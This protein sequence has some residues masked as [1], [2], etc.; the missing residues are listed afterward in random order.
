MQQWQSTPQ[1][2]SFNGTNRRCDRLPYVAR[3][4]DRLH[5]VDVVVPDDGVKRGVQVVEKVHD[6][7]K[8]GR[9]QCAQVLQPGSAAIFSLNTVPCTKSQESNNKKQCSRQ[10]QCEIPCGV[11]NV[12]NSSLFI[13]SSLSSLSSTLH[14]VCRGGPPPVGG[15]HLWQGEGVWWGRGSG[16]GRG[17]GGLAGG[18]GAEDISVQLPYTARPQGASPQRDF[19]Q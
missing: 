15:S 13:N 17:R 9:S 7:E 12:V 3:L 14:A 19:A 10:L 8:V 5:F 11:G 16:R 1:V 6:L 18:R 2:Y 4:T